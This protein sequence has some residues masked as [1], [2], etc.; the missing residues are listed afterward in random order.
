MTDKPTTPED[1]ARKIRRDRCQARLDAFNALEAD[2]QAAIRQ[3]F[4]ALEAA[5]TT[6]SDC[7]DLWLSDN[8]E[9]DRAL[10]HLRS[11]AIFDPENVDL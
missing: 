10:W 4:K 1:L 2:Q 7:Q 11:L 5:Q 9:F 8:K 6:L 3:T